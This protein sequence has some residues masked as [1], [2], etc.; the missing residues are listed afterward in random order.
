[1]F[2]MAGSAGA[3]IAAQRTQ[4]APEKT[5]A[6][7][8]HTFK[9]C[10][11]FP[12]QYKAL[13]FL[14]PPTYQ[15]VCLYIRGQ[16]ESLVS[17]NYGIIPKENVSYS[18]PLAREINPWSHLGQRTPS[19]M[20]CQENRNMLKGDLVCLL[21]YSRI[22]GAFYT[23]EARALESAWQPLPSLLQKS[24]WSRT[25]KKFKFVENQN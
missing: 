20:E 12:F 18:S 4:S 8:Q 25:S 19:M 9:K 16:W 17:H 6:P 1:M 15:H 21:K 24:C 23:R 14:F 11:H 3:A 2:L 13:Y 7:A 10:L 5:L 22:I